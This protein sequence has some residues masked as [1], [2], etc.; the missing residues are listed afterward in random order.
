VCF[1]RLFEL[2]VD[3]YCTVSHMSALGWEEGA[4][5]WR[6][7]LWVWEEKMLGECV[8]LLRSVSL[9][10]NVTNSWRWQLDPCAD[11]TVCGAYQLLTSRDIP[12]GE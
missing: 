6:R 11:Y 2:V 7:R 12:Q 4:W 3:K 9:Q 8:T 5:I 1:R 10:F